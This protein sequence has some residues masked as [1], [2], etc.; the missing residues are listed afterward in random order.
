MTDHNQQHLNIPD[1]EIIGHIDRLVEEEHRLE[2][3]HVGEGLDEAGRARLSQLEVQL[4]QAWDLLRQRRARRSAGL[5]PD[6]AELRDPS[7]VERYQQ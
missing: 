3:E 6:Q 2:R 7:V 1:A 4:D 5:D